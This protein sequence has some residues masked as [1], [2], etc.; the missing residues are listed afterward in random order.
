MT[1]EQVKEKVSKAEKDILAIVKDIESCGVVVDFISIDHN[2]IM[3]EP[4]KKS[5]GVKLEVAL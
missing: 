4:A 2:L 1:I 5:V 3:S